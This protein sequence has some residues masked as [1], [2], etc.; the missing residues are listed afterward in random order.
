MLAGLR[1]VAELMWTA[2]ATRRNAATE[3]HIGNQVI[4]RFEMASALSIARV[5]EWFNV[6]GQSN[7]T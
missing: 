3:E 5:A 2:K 1:I 4:N 6:H 7:L